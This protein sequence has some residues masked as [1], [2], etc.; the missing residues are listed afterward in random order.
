MKKLK[1]R[2]GV[3]TL[4]K[5]GDGVFKQ[6]TFDED[7]ANLAFLYLSLIH[8]SDAAGTNNVVRA[9]ASGK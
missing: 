1:K 9:G 3:K 2:P 7:G 8:I 5:E 6:V 4:I